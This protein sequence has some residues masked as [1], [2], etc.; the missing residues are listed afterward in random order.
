MEV[1]EEAEPGNKG[2]VPR[3]IAKAILKNTASTTKEIEAKRR[4][5]Q[6]ALDS[7]EGGLFIGTAKDRYDPDDLTEP[8]RNRPKYWYKVKGEIDFERE[9]LTLS[10]TIVNLLSKELLPPT[11]HE[12]ISGWLKDN[13]PKNGWLHRVESKSRYPEISLASDQTSSARK[14]LLTALMENKAFQ[15][16]Y[17]NI[18][19]AVFYPLRLVQRERVTYLICGTE[20][21][22]EENAGNLYTI[23]PYALHRFRDVKVRERSFGMVSDALYALT[24]SEISQKMITP[25]STEG[26]IEEGT[27]LEK[28]DIR[29]FGIPAQHLSEI[30]FHNKNGDTCTER[31]II[32][33]DHDGRVTEVVLRSKN[34]VYS[35][36]LKC[37]IL[38]LGGYARVE[39]PKSLRTLVKN[40]IEKMTINYNG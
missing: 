27:L 28:F 19:K 17:M 7:A 2:L 24:Q 26:A 8:E 35:Y 14:I 11:L 31:E 18:T 10:L 22:P 12:K 30:T 33:R 5:V 21:S 9:E 29:I 4:A 3:A 16:S 13:E 40:E 6:R 38:G 32:S 36:E 34:V 37:W 15:A 25:T 39:E 1:L 23:K 20:A